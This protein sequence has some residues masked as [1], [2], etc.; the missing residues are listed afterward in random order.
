MRGCEG[1]RG[2][3]EGL[4]GVYEGLRGAWEGLGGVC[5]GLGGAWEGRG[6][7]SEIVLKISLCAF[8]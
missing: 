1:L 6:R 3:W 7:S 5:E 4:G 2:A 8:S